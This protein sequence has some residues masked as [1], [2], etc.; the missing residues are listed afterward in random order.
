[1]ESVTYN[2]AEGGQ[3]QGLDIALLYGKVGEFTVSLIV[4]S[5]DNSTAASATGA[6]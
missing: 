4:T 3:S 2:F 6:V 5:D 1:M